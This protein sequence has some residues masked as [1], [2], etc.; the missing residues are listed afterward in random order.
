MLSD[1]T[2]PLDF[3]GTVSCL[4]NEIQLQ[5]PKGIRMTL[6]ENIRI[7]DSTGQVLDCGNTKGKTLTVPDKCTIQEA[8]RRVLHLAINTTKEQTTYRVVCFDAQDDEVPQAADVTCGDSKFTAKIPR[9]LYGFDD[10]TVVPIKHPYWTISIKGANPETMS[11]AEA[12]KAGYEILS[13]VSNFIIQAPYNAPGIRSWNV[14]NQMTYTGNIKL[15]SRYQSQSIV[16]EVAIICYKGPPICNNTYMMIKMPNFGGVLAGLELDNVQ[17]PMSASALQQKGF[18]VDTRNGIWLYIKSSILKRDGN[19]SY[20]NSL[21]AYFNLD[22]SIIPMLINAKCVNDQNPPWATCTT[23]GNMRFEVLDSITSPP[24]DLTTVRLG[25]NTCKPNT[26]FKNRLIFNVPLNACG[27]KVKFI[28]N[29]AIFENELYAFWN[30]ARL[31]R[32]SRDSDY[33]VTVRCYY[34]SLSN[35]TVIVNVATLPPP[36]SSKS[37]GPL[38]LIL[39]LYPDDAYTSP[40]SSFLYPIVKTLRDPIYLEVQL[41]NR[42]DPNIE[43]VLDDCWATMSKDPNTLPKWGILVD[44]CPVYEDS[45]ITVLH[46]VGSNVPLPSYR[47]WFEV[48]TFSFVSNGEATTNLI[49]FHCSA[50]VCDTTS[51]DSPLCTKICPVARRRRDKNHLNKESTLVSLPGPIKFLDPDS[52]VQQYEDHANVVME[53]LVTVVLPL[54]GMSAVIVLAVV[55]ILVFKWKRTN[56]TLSTF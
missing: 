51:P 29:Y 24:L 9:T 46:R 12:K 4:D 53:Q 14:E 25:D 42:N 48:K 26:T 20:L 49:Y 1:A 23:D 32:I 5:K 44:G 41:L 40:Y 50:I 18:I 3:P 16:I 39:D 45:S 37:D 43:L 15:S 30:D 56:V 55:V 2:K 13:D 7:V 10:E 36:V 11:L 27:T 19:T 22:D 47:K 31:R 52:R 17:L 34:R 38:S 28:D 6:W 35:A 21:L 33:R 54:I 8:G